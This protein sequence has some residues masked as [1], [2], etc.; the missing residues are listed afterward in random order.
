M[1]DGNEVKNRSSQSCHTRHNDLPE[2]TNSHSSHHNHPSDSLGTS[3]CPFNLLV[4]SS[5]YCKTSSYCAS[6]LA[7]AI[8]VGA[9][10]PFAGSQQLYG[11]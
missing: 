10:S 6:S 8:D 4:V 5:Y 9:S 1:L 2:G 3:Q 11:D 7:N